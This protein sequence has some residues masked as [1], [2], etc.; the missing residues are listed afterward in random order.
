[1]GIEVR[2]LRPGDEEIVRRLSLDRSRF[3]FA[4][5]Q[6]RRPAPSAKTARAFLAEDKVVHLTAFLDGDVVG[7]VLAYELVRRHGDG[8]MLLVYEIGVREDRRRSGVGRHLFAALKS[9]CRGRNIDRAFVITSEAN[10]AAMR[11]YEALGGFRPATDDVVF[12]FQ[13][14]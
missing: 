3:E 14:D 1:V 8:T 10:T 6:R 12:D 11:F 4:S 2:R 5:D 7:H 9:Y 13:W